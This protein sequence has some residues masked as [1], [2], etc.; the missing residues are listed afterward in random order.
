MLSASI[1]AVGHRYGA[2]PHENS[3]T[4]GQVL[5]LVTA[6][7]GLHNNHHAA[8]TS[9]RFSLEAGEVDPG[10]WVVRSLVALHLARVRHDDVHFAAPSRG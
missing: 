6:G 8:P 2:R 5:A 3:A 4:N 10:W 1:N 7:E 9:A